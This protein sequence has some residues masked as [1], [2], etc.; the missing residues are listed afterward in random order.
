MDW[1]AGFALSFGSVRFILGLNWWSIKPWTALDLT[2]ILTL[3]LKV[4]IIAEVDSLTHSR[5]QHM[6]VLAAAAKLK[7]DKGH[8]GRK[9]ETTVVSSR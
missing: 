1:V 5:L 4:S 9:K 6:E 7:L 8:F 2:K 3:N